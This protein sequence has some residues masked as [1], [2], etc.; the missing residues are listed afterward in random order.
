MDEFKNMQKQSQI[1]EDDLRSAEDN[2]QKITDKKSE[3]IDTIIQSKEK[4]VTSI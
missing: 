2:I 1:T 3:Q 4:E